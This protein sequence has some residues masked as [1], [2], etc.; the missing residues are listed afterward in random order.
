MILFRYAEVLLNYAEAKAELGELTQEDVDKTINLLRRR[1]GVADLR[2]DAIV[3][4]PNW[5]FPEIS[6]LLNEIRRER[7]VEFACEG[8][9]LNDLLRWRAHELFVNKR[10]KGFYFNQSDFP[11]MIP[12]KDI[13]LD[14]QGYVD[15]YKQSLPN[16]YQFN[17]E[18]DYLLPLPTSELVLNSKL[19]QNPGW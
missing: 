10:P 7:R 5:K 16:G 4:D 18:R 19:K 6:P 15:P 2:I 12:N 8:Y 13:L 17:P 11:E 3:N 14:E 1:V 9:R